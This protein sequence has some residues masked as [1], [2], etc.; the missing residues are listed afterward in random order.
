MLSYILHINSNGSNSNSNSSSSS[1]SGHNGGQDKLSPLISA[2][3]E[4]DHDLV[5]DL[6]RLIGSLP[7]SLSLSPAP[8]TLLYTLCIF[9]TLLIN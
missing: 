3:E 9:S 6:G 7:H 4:L 8:Y 1:S 5:D 2:F